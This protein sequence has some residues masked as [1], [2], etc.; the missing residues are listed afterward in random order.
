MADGKAEKTKVVSCL[1]PAS[2][3]LSVGGIQGHLKFLTSVHE[4]VGATA[5][6]HRTAILE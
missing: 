6:E 4:C 3:Q 1:Q 2:L 5:A